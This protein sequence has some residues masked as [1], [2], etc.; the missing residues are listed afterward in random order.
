[1]VL[2]L[3]G[4]L[5]V[6]QLGDD[7]PAD[8]DEQTLAPVAASSDAPRRA[9]LAELATASDLVV[10]A[11]VVATDRGRVFGDPGSDAAIESRVVTLTIRRVLRGIGTSPDATLLV[12][13]EGWTADGAPLVVD[14]APPSE[15]GDDAIWFLTEVGAEEEQ[16]YVVVSAEGRYVVDASGLRGAVGDD[17]LVAELAA[18]GPDGLE[19]AIAALR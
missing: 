10:R 5:V 1:V 2:A 19:A 17:P 15:V 12:E 3:S 9:S 14:G 7:G 6:W 11:Q 8:R 18:L 16:R 4:G 13:E